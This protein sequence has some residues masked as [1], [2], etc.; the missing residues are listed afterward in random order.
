M[1]KL[2]SSSSYLKIDRIIGKSSLTKIKKTLLISV[3][4]SVNYTVI[5]I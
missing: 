3:I 5:N 2:V 1:V 4:S